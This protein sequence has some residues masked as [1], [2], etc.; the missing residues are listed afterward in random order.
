MN[1]GKETRKMKFGLG[2]IR[3][4][5]SAEGFKN[6]FKSVIVA[7]SDGK[8]QTAVFL[9]RLLLASGE[10]AGSYL[11]PHLFRSEEHTSE[12]QSH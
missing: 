11:S 4:V 1:S 9:E 5:L 6:A 7:G 12:L 10:K 3:R 2:R 8:S